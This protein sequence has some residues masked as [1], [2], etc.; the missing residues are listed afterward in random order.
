MRDPRHMPR[1]VLRLVSAAASLVMLVSLLTWTQAT[2]AIAD[3]APAPTIPSTVS[4]DPL[5][6]PQINGVV[7]DQAIVGNTVYVAGNFTKA[8]PFG[9]A[10]G[11]NEVD[12]AY[13][14][15]YDLTTGALL[16]WA[17]AFNAQVRAIAGSPDGTRLYAAGDFTTIDGTPKSRIAAFDTATGALS[18]AFDARAN[19][20]VYAVVA[21][22]TAVYFSGPFTSVSGTTRLGGAAALASN[23]AVTAWAPELAGG[24]AYGIVISPDESKVVIGGDFTTV[25]GSGDPGYGLAMVDATAGA[26]ITPFTANVLVRN[27]GL[28]SAIFSLASD[29]DS[30]YGSGYVF[31]SGGN[32]EGTFRANWSDGA[33]VWINDCHGDTYSVS[34]SPSGAIYTAGHAHYC[35]NIDSFPQ[36]EPWTFYRGM[37]F[38]KEPTGTISRDPYGYKNWAGNPRSSALN[39]FPSINLGSFTGQF[40]G[41]WDVTANAQYAVYGGEF[42]SVNGVQQQG[43]VRF[44]VASIAPNRDGPRLSGANLV[45]TMSSP[46]AGTIALSW[47]ANWDRDNENLTY[48]LIR[49]GRTASPIYVTTQD[50]RFYERPTMTYL[51]TGLTPGQ[52]YTYRLRAIDPFGNSGWGSTVSYTASDTGELSDYAAAVMED[53]PTNY[54]RLGDTGGGTAVDSVGRD[55]ATANAGVGFGAPGAVVGDSDDA[56]VFTGSN[57]SF[58]AQRTQQWRDNTFSVEAWFKTS[59]TVGGKIVGFGSSSTGNSG[60]Y[61]RH[62]YMDASGRVNFGVYPGTSRVIQSAK[63]YNDDAW[64]YVVGSMGPDGMELYIDG[65]R[66]GADPTTTWGQNYW[67]YWRIGGDNS[68][69]GAPYFTGSIDEVAVYPKPLTASQIRNRYLLSGRT[70]TEPVVPTDAYGAAVYAS[71]P[72]LYWRLSEE[73][74]AAVTDSGPQGIGGALSGTYTR[75]VP[76]ALEGTA[77]TAT[78]F[79]QGSA[80][81]A[82]SLP[83]PSTFSSEVW[84]RTTTTSG[85]KLMGFGSSPSG[86]SG[87]YGDQVIMRD[88]GTLLFGTGSSTVTTTERFNDGEWHQVV[89][90]QST[91]GLRLY[92]DGEL[93][94]SS[95][96][97]PS[98]T[99]TGYWRL[100]RD[101]TGGASSSAFFAGDLD[102][103]AVYPTVVSASDVRER[104][105]LGLANEAPIAAFTHTA[106][107]LEASFDASGS[108]DPDGTIQSY[109]WDFGDGS[110]GEGATAVHAFAGA[111]TYDVTLT[112]TDDQGASTT[113]EQAVAVVAPNVAPA[114]DF[115]VDVTD[116]AI[117][118]DAAAST[119]PDGEIV[120]YGWEFGDG[121]TATGA[122]ASHV[123]G[124]DGTYTVTLTVTDDRGATAVTTREVSAVA[125]PAAVVVASDDFTRS[126]TSG[127]G[128]AAVGGEWSPNLRSAFSVAAGAGVVTHGTPGTTRSA[129]LGSVSTD[130]VTVSA[131]VSVDKVITGGGAYAGLIVREVGSGF[132]QARVRYL[133]SGAIALQALSGSSTVI[134]S[135]NVD[136]V[137][138]APG[139]VLTVKAQAYGTSPTTIRAKVWKSGTPEPAAWMLETTS[140]ATGLQAAGS[141]GVYSY[142]SASTTNAP[143]RVRY[144]G[145][146]AVAG[147][148]DGAGPTPN[149]APT[150]AFTSSVT[151]LSAAFDS[152]GSADLDGVIVSRAWSFGDG[153]SSADV[154]PQHTYASAGTY[155]VTLTVTDD[156]G[157]T[158][159][160]TRDVTVQAPAPNTP[161]AAVF[162]AATAGLGVTVDASGSSDP[163]GAIVTYAWTFGDGQSATGATAAHQYA[164]AGTYTV[165]LV[166]TDDDGASASASAQVTVTAP[167][168][169]VDP[170]V[171]AQDDFER[172]AS[173]GWGTATVGG[174]WTVSTNAAFSVSGGAGT[175]THAA[176]GTTRRALLGAVSQSAIDLQVEFSSDKS[177]EVGHIVVGVVGRQVG[178]AFYQA[179]ARLLPGGAVGLQL[180]SGSSTVLA[181]ITVPGL[182]YAP[183]ETLVLRSVVSGTSPTTLAAKLWRKGAAE[184]TA[185][186]VSATDSTAALQTAGSI[187]YESYVSGSA[188]NAPIAIRVDNLL[189]RA[190]Q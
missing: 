147:H 106:V 9:S 124:A 173:P 37:A 35:G 84:F 68:W 87:S 47:T 99:F 1:P 76:G 54:W 162:S 74:G 140:S 116:N 48:Q 111:G 85:G 182:T 108:S 38:S 27:A 189:A 167:E 82:I 141:V 19:Y 178:T 115:T 131:N 132:Y 172:T 51:D 18:T 126:E 109:R 110:T 163:D 170:V 56:A 61:D 12:R 24:R 52:T 93:A 22:N 91:A 44:A 123:Y 128:V 188:P 86:N 31:G 33:I 139:D 69:S 65:V 13:M 165:G 129:R 118:V 117:A 32:L 175:A 3:T 161:P 57:D 15:A 133:S 60:S 10:P 59:T 4:T 154:S 71:A 174:A 95:A 83:N 184:P 136:G 134:A 145:F 150:A 107:D 78:R 190:P 26:L 70:T 64:H 23:G 164:A 67:G 119:D 40:Q 120:S 177:A 157:A 176:P 180:L 30:F 114:A 17:P 41:P 149:L 90:T 20:R 155:P 92:V 153:G 156:R 58:T 25:N 66:V 142:V 45:P 46:A 148:A 50:S 158:A 72:Q 75:N 113:V 79:T 6:T 39:F 135:T 49:D 14:L 185:W 112:V 103:F 94:R 62:I 28:N 151:G 73:A 166:V 53:Q 97:N 143:V 187:G 89:A 42:T 160:V 104:Y 144:H 101:N 7:W 127:W 138:V 55:D 159:Q 2:A 21:T 105:L 36:T 63:A 152:T 181:N 81:S 98:Q 121:A 125:P 43:L 29:S 169:P 8:R 88:D 100:G 179:R 102:E 186:Q 130:D 122:T 171:L 16:P 96:A 137:T 34:P 5:P 80:A 146:L 183:G 77:D 11:V 168:G